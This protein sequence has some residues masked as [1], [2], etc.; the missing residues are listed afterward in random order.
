MGI[1][2]FF[3]QKMLESKLK[4]VPKDQQEKILMMLQ[5]DPALFQKI[6]TE[7]EAETKAGKDQMAAA[8]QVMQK[9]KDQIQGLMQ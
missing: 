4:G 9:Y 6:G 7:I 5:K 8:M 1:K 2:D 3:L